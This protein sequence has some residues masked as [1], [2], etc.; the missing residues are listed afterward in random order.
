[1]QRYH[2]GMMDK[3]LLL[4]VVGITSLLTDLGPGVREYGY[5][6]VDE[7]QRM[8]LSDL[9]NPSTIK[10]QALV[11][12]MK[13]RMYTRRFTAAFMLAAI[14][15]R[16]ASALRLNFENPNLCFLARES[17]RRLMWAF[18]TIDSGINGGY[19]NFTVLPAD[20]MHIQ[21]PCNERNFEF[22]LPQ[23]TQ[24]LRPIPERPF[25][26]D[27]GSLASHVRLLWIRSRILY[28]TKNILAMPESELRELPRIIGAL[29]Q[30]L[31]SFNERLPVSFRFSENNIK[32]RTYSPRLCVFMML[33]VWF[34]Q[35][36]CDL[37]RVVLTGMKGALPRSAIEKLPPQFVANCERQCYE[38]AVAMADIFRVLL[39]LDGGLPVSDLDLPVC[40]YECA[41][42]LFFGFRTNAAGFPLNAEQVQ[43]YTQ[44]CLQVTRHMIHIPAGLAIVSCSSSYT[45]LRR[46]AN[47]YL[48][49]IMI[50]RS[51]LLV[52]F[53]QA[54]HQEGQRA[55]RLR[56]IVYCR[57]SPCLG[58]THSTRWIS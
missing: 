6:C 52:V 1:M 26:E 23:A 51:L 30:E 44:R 45:Y 57:L 47:P 43:E 50:W 4:A 21:L 17:R 37:F 48:V 39:S 49:S 19:S 29:T 34:R 40:A 24:H 28:C 46:C 31:I 55:P 33:H 38:H 25:V 20:A 53:P 9:E 3:T 5:K 10:I 35:C 56:G 8:I 58:R 22:D 54:L 27:I 41:R 2:A 36:H 15:G 7:C 14:V 16:F 18:L 12:V 32:L 11:L 42:I 13:H